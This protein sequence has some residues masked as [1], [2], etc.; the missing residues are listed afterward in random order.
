MDS[1]A[2]ARLAELKGDV[3]RMIN[4][5]GSLSA[6]LGKKEIPEWELLY[7]RIFIKGISSE[8][9][10]ILGEQG[11]DISDF[12]AIH[13]PDACG[14]N[15]KAVVSFQSWLSERLHQLAP[16]SLMKQNL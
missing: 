13:K 10:S 9:I 5:V 12:N 8:V 6:N 2:I 7:Q 14:S 4:K 11:I 15:E 16:A 3:D 1:K